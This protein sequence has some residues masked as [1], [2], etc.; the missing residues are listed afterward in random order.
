M[1]RSFG[2]HHAQKEKRVLQKNAIQEA[3][4]SKRLVKLY[5]VKG[6]KTEIRKFHLPTTFLLHLYSLS[7]YLVREILPKHLENHPVINPC[8]L[9]LQYVDDENDRVHL[10]GKEEFEIFTSEIGKDQSSVVKLVIRSID[11]QD[12]EEKGS[13]SEWTQ[14]EMSM[15]KDLYYQYKYETNESNEYKLA[16]D[17]AE[18]AA[19]ALFAERTKKELEWLILTNP[20]V[21]KNPPPPPSKQPLQRPPPQQAWGESSRSYHQAPSVQQ[22][23]QRAPTTTSVEAPMMQPRMHQQ[24]PPNGSQYQPVAQPPM[25]QR[26]FGSFQPAPQQQPSQYGVPQQVPQVNLQQRPILFPQAPQQ[27]VPQQRAT[28]QT[29][30]DP[31]QFTESVKQL[32]SMGFTDDAK[33]T[34]LLHKHNG[35]IDSVVQALVSGN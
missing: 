6:E 34:E 8:R 26:S 11:A 35:N 30:V 2:R 1:R 3:R 13:W 4:A 15:L 28:Q 32:N 12:D 27:Q 19:G 21:K 14:S 24:F 20:D 16:R 23:M 5:I 29:P 31:T 9:H 7:L 18:K 10:T 17:V 33:I 22:P 25:M